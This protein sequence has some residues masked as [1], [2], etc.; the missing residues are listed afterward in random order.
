MDV[1]GK[2]AFLQQPCASKVPS[3]HSLIMLGGLGFG[4]SE[5]Y[6]YYRHVLEIEVGRLDSGHWV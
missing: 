2:L 1:D 6:E 3:H 5:L 4:D